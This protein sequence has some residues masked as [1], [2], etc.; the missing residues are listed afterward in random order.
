MMHLSLGFSNVFW[1]NVY[2]DPGIT[3]VVIPHV[4]SPDKPRQL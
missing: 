2:A 1:K 4:S 3:A